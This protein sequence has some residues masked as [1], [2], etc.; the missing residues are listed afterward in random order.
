MMNNSFGLSKLENL[1]S[2]P[3]KVLIVDDHA[4]SRMNA[5]DLLSLEGYEISE[6]DNSLAALDR[7]IADRPDLILLD[8]MMPQMDGFEV[9]RQLKQDRRTQQIPVILITVAEDRQLRLKWKEVGADELMLKPL[10]PLELSTRVKSLIQGKRVKEGLDQTEQVLFSIAKAIESRYSEND[11]SSAKLAALAEAFG[12]YLVLSPTEI[13]DLK[14]AA[15]I[16]DIGT[17]VIPD[18]VMRKK[19]K[20]TEEEQELIRQHVLIGEQIC[21]PMRFRSGVLPIIRHHH[22]R[23]DGSGYPDGLVGEEIPYL[24]QI[25]QI[26]DIYTA[27]NS[28]RPHKEAIDPRQAVEIIVEETKKGWRNPELV[29]QFTRFIDRN[30]KSIN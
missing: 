10:D 2:S 1:S 13:Q 29:E 9:C 19:G 27:L 15:H 18:A 28:E 26:L 23:W 30:F 8:V 22:E 24:A 20:L 14:F 7:A 25:F 11:D 5:A 17:I 6:S 4:F 21:Q 3:A 12:E 16:H